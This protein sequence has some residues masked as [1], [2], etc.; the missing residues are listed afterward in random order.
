MNTTAFIK[1]ECANHRKSDSGCW[2]DDE[3]CC[4]MDGKRC[5][6]FEMC[7]LP[8]A[9]QPSPHGQTGNRYAKG[10]QQQRQQARSEYVKL[11]GIMGDALKGVGG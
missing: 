3:P 4:V 7:V 10:L 1:A 11:H 2:P 6:Y 8:I 5:S 9:D